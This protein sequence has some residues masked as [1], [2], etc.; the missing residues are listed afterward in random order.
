MANYQCQNFV[1][2]TLGL[3]NSPDAMVRHPFVEVHE[4]LERKPSDKR[5]FYFN[6]IGVLKFSKGRKVLANGKIYS[7]LI[8]INGRELN[9]LDIKLN[10]QLYC[11]KEQNIPKVE[12]GDLIYLKDLMSIESL[13][14]I[15]PVAVYNDYSSYRVMRYQ[16]VDSLPIIEDRICFFTQKELNVAQKLALKLMNG[17]MKIE[18]QTLST[19]SRFSV[20]SYY[21]IVAFIV[22]K[23][24]C[25]GDD[26]KERYVI[27]RVCDG[28]K[29]N[30]SALSSLSENFQY[31]DNSDY[32]EYL[33]D[34]LYD[35]YVFDD[36]INSSR[37][38]Q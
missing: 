33:K 26:N 21:N 20:L 14:D 18:N 8:I 38:F 13:S 12:P 37:N 10:V 15:N 36:H 6:T 17:E 4:I 1:T 24:E 31:V 35:V 29:M 19:L 7:L 25:Y 22:G 5:K 32:K 11:L 34:Y 23:Y 16:I 30:I 3:F 2:A 28:T 27:L 9:G